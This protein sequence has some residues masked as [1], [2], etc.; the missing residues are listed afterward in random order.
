MAKRRVSKK[1]AGRWPH[2]KTMSGDLNFTDFSVQNTDSI[3]KLLSAIRKARAGDAED[4]RC[5]DS[6][7]Q[8]ECLLL[9][10]LREIQDLRA[11][12]L[13]TH[14]N[15][16]LISNVL[17]AGALNFPTVKSSLTP[18]EIEA[19]DRRREIML[20]RAQEREYQR[21]VAPLT[22][23]ATKA[24]R[25]Q[26][27]EQKLQYQLGVPVNMVLGGGTAFILGY[28]SGMHYFGDHNSALGVGCVCLFIMLFIEMMLF[29]IR[30]I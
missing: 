1:F 3:K 16:P 17:S 18:E 25:R 24:K 9:K 4:C 30:S 11:S 19:Q 15:L 29:T 28:Y 10:D 20:A 2:L 7:L 26:I 5:V 14:A 22:A 21:M 23:R 6:L 12:A 27:F 13:K 8:K